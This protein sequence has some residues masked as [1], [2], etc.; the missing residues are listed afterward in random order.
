MTARDRSQ[1]AATDVI[2]VWH[3]C[4]CDCERG[5]FERQP[6]AVALALRGFNS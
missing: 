2:S 4:H 3:L 6:F 1:F 5:T